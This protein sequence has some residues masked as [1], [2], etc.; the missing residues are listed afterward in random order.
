MR[1]AVRESNS[2]SS[3]SVCKLAV[4]DLFN[5]YIGQA[6][7]ADQFW[8]VKMKTAVTKRFPFILTPE[9][10][11]ESYDLRAVL[12]LKLTMGLL[13]RTNMVRLSQ[14]SSEDFF[15]KE[16]KA[17]KLVFT[18]IEEICV[19]VKN[20]CLGEVF[21]AFLCLDQAMRTDNTEGA[22]RLLNVAKMRIIVAE[23]KN[24]LAFYVSWLRAKICYEIAL[25][26]PYP[27]MGDIV[28]AII[29]ERLE[30]A[31]ELSPNRASL[32]LWAKALAL[33]AKHKD[34]LGQVEEAAKL[35]QLQAEKEALAEKYPH[36][37]CQFTNA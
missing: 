5:I 36:I 14:G 6:D 4:L 16:L 26:V 20:S 7:K 24:P 37:D 8:K 13:L 19:V 2:L 25:R 17:V 28:Y 22:L 35:R 32:D 21:D 29:Y 33:Q 1:K 3:E 9:E 31:F 23:G 11:A 15:A 10:K 12:C 34:S 18:D 27:L 30:V